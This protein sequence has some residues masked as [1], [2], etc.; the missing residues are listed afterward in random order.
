MLSPLE[1]KRLT[2]LRRQ[3]EIAEG[4]YARYKDSQSAQKVLNTLKM[5]ESDIADLNVD[6]QFLEEKDDRLL[7]VEDVN[8]GTEDQL[9]LVKR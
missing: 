4:K 3:K 2:W 9:D 8:A 1:K 6:I 7:K 5:I